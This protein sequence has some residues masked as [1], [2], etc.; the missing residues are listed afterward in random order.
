VAAPGDKGLGPE[1]D[2]GRNRLFAYSAAQQ[3]RSQHGGGRRPYH[4]RD[5]Q[6]SCSYS[7]FNT[8]GWR[9]SIVLPLERFYLDFSTL[10]LQESYEPLPFSGEKNLEAPDFTPTAGWGEVVRLAVS[11]ATSGGDSHLLRF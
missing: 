2:C 5:S 6:I 1:S 7:Y 8:F 11:S 10:F 4:G 3:A 9:R